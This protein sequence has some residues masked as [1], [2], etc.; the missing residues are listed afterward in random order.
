MIPLLAKQGNFFTCGRSRDN[1]FDASIR[2]R[3]SWISN[4]MQNISSLNSFCLVIRY[5]HGQI[6]CFIKLTGSPKNDVE[7]KDQYK[8]PELQSM[9]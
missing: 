9:N 8:C 2:S 7:C 4:F 5:M 3:V 6:L 1:S